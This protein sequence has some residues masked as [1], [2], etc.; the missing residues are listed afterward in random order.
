[1]AKRMKIIQKAREQ[2]EFKKVWTQ[3]GKILLWAL[4][5]RLFYK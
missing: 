5:T 3:G 2:H 4:V 1:M